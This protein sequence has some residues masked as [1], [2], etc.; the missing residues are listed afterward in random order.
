MIT[1]HL[2]MQLIFGGFVN[3]VDDTNLTF[4]CLT[5]LL[6]MPNLE[7][8]VFTLLLVV[9]LA[10]SAEAF[11]LFNYDFPRFNPSPFFY[12]VFGGFGG[13]DFFDDD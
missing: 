2:Y 3:C 1:T 9:V 8:L 13:D 12:P 7:S 4:F 6:R 11:G 10:T 5:E